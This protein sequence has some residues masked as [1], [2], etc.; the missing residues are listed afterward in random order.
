MSEE[1]IMFV[2]RLHT[3]AILIAMPV[4]AAAQTPA[5]KIAIGGEVSVTGLAMPNQPEAGS[6]RE[7]RTRARI[8]VTADP[9]PWLRLKL[10]GTVDGLLADRQGRVEDLVARAREVWVEARGARADLRV[11]YGRLIW[12]R[13]DEIMPSDVINPIDT[14]R[15]FLEGRA[16]ARL[17]VAFTRGRLFLSDATTLEAIVSLPGRRGRFDE[18]DEP[19]SPF[20]LTRD[21]VFA[22]VPGQIRRI[23]PEN[24]W[25]N[26]QVGGR[27]STTLGR[28]DASVSAYRGFESFGTLSLEPGFSSEQPSFSPAVTTLV[29]GELVERYSKFTMVATDA[30]AVVGPWA[31]RGEVAY[32]PDRQ[33]TGT[34]GSLDGRALDA[35]I[36]VDRS[37]GDYRV[38]TSVVWHRDWTSEGPTLVNNDLSVIG[39]IERR[40][41][42]DRY[43]VRVFGVANPVDESGFLRGLAAWSMR[44]NV[45]LEASAGLLFGSASSTDTLSRFRDRDF[46]FARVRW[47]F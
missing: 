44:D 1:Q 18:L 27:A 35:G 25:D 16:E 39:S 38:F 43:L 3:L 13:L 34:F 24:S 6:T 40:F 37:A 30:E 41:S 42:R 47:F 9:S 31:I 2:R 22:A 29:V 14:S 11:G 5:T 12:G 23:E 20:N 45:A 15:Y 4:V 19:T 21:L 26:L 33:V 7:F 17:P 32:F 28:V 8:E 46:A 36:G 10:E